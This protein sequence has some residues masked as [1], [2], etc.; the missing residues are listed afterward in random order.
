VT[1]VI[2]MTVT[3]VLV[4]RQVVWV[5]RMSDDANVRSHDVS[6]QRTVRNQWSNGSRPRGVRNCRRLPDTVVTLYL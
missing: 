3:G 1:H 4:R 6:S 5:V 2:E